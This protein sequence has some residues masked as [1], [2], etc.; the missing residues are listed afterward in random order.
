MSHLTDR[1]CLD[2][3]VLSVIRGECPASLKQAQRRECPDHLL[4]GHCT[5][6]TGDMK[7]KKASTNLIAEIPV[8]DTIDLDDFDSEALSFHSLRECLPGRC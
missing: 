7:G 5:S 8:G 1:E 2:G 6:H 3:P 4:A